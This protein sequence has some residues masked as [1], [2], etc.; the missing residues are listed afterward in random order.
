MV[1]SPPER[2]LPNDV[3]D[4]GQLNDTKDDGH[5]ERVSFELSC[6][7]I[8]EITEENW[9]EKVLGLNQLGLVGLDSCRHF[10]SKKKER[11]VC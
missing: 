11:T 2:S 6:G 7:R 9:A 8:G 3:A 4:D 1:I 10:Y 5:I